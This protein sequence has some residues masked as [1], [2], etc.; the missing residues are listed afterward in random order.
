MSRAFCFFLVVIAGRMN[1]RDQL[2]IEYLLEEIRVLR[3][4]LGQKRIQYSNSQRRRLARAAKRVGRKALS[5]I[6]TLV[7]PDTLL[8]WHRQLVAEKW[9]YSTKS[10]RAPGRPPVS[11]DVRDLI[12]R[13]AEE[14]PGWGYRRICGV[15]KTL[16]VSVCAQTVANVLRDAGIDPAPERKARTKWRDFI[17]RHREAMWATD[18]F[19]AEI[20]SQGKLTT[21]HVL[22]F[23]E[24]ATRRLFWAGS[25]RIRMKNGR[26]RRRGSLQPSTG[27]FTG[28]VFLKDAFFCGIGMRNTL[29]R[30]IRC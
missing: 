2:V 17:N 7:T 23:I 13:L 26:C 28:R 3:E 10:G 4:M 6:S 21:F 15:L 11:Q 8:R 20:W 27:R 12:L 9:T 22:F 29:L 24:I 19:S 18:F 5:K 14:N 1:E 30:L 25:R 16:E